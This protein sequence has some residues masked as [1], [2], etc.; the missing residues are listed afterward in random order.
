MFFLIIHEPSEV[1][2]LKM[3]RI[4]KQKSNK[5]CCILNGNHSPVHSKISEQP[6]SRWFVFSLTALHLLLLSFRTSLNSLVVFS[7]DFSW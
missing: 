1:T 3:I 5:T 6:L 4:S 2:L 7:S